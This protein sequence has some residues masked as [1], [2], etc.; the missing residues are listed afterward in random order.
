MRNLII[1]L[2]V[3]FLALSSAFSTLALAADSSPSADIKGKLEEL[4]KEIA[5]KA[6]QL[7]K[8]VDRKLKDKAYIG[9]VKSKSDTS[10]TLAVKS[11][12]KIV[13]LNQDTVFESDVKGKKFSQKTLS[14]ENYVAALGDID[15]TGVLTAK[16]IILL[17]E[18]D[19]PKSYLWGQVISAN[20]KITVKTRDSKNIPASIPSSSSVKLNDF[21]ILAGNKDKND[22]FVSE[23]VYVVPQGIIIKPKNATPSAQVS[24]SSAN[25]QKKK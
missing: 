2:C 15:E 13:S 25:Q 7:K 1:I 19:M 22:I 16:R 6:A 24:S 12:T 18:P 14:E 9:K 3:S 17:P 4:K 21:V 23:F 10:I 20:S 5:S 11:G 8:V